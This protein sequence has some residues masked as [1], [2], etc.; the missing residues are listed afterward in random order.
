MKSALYRMPPLLRDRLSG[1]LLRSYEAYLGARQSLK[2]NR[3]F[4]DGLSVPPPALRVKVVGHADAEAFLRGGRRDNEIIREAL[5][6]AGTEAKTLER[7]LDWGCGCGRVVRWWSDLSCTDIDACDYNA[8]LVEW[9]DHNL[10]FVRAR[11]NGIHP[12][13][14]YDSGCFDLVYAISVFTH[15]TDDLVVAWMSDIH[16]VLV[17]GGRF[18]FTTHGELYRD[19]LT[20][21]EAARFD[22]GESVVQFP[23]V[24]GSNLCAAYH[25][26]AWIESR[27]LAGFEL[28][29]VREGHTLGEDERRELAQDRWLIR[30]LA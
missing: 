2:E 12:R 5:A 16:R 24:V 15:L 19:R 26:R 22:G 28:V 14:P 20:L 3:L 9:V 17:P 29:E 10:P 23:S 18:F 21:P 25:P 27:T 13:L 7:I 4:D 11:T 30:K 6:R 1:T 8:D